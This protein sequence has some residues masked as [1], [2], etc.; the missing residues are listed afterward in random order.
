L[1]KSGSLAI[2]CIVTRDGH[3]RFFSVST[4]FHAMVLGSGVKEIT[5]NVFHVAPQSRY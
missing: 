4:N 2:G 5:K 1:Q 3:L